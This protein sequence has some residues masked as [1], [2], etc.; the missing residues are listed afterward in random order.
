MIFPLINIFF[1]RYFHYYPSWRDFK[2]SA[3]RCSL[4]CWLHAVRVK[5]SPC[6]MAL[7]LWVDGPEGGKREKRTAQ[8]LQPKG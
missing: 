7:S 2:E 8:E 4:A 5:N 6:Y 3:E 1:N